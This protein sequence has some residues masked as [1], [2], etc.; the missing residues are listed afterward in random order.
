[1]CV[2]RPWDKTM[3]SKHKHHSKSHNKCAE[4]VLYDHSNNNNNKK[5]LS[6]WLIITM[7]SPKTWHNDLQCARFAIANDLK[8]FIRSDPTAQN[9]GGV[10]N[11]PE[12][13]CSHTLGAI[14]FLWVR[15]IQHQCVFVD[16][17]CLP[18]LRGTGKP[19]SSPDHKS[20]NHLQGICSTN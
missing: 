15:V 7:A 9:V 17:H 6:L 10:W 11:S 18:K 3:W 2:K 5:I 19:R 1:M 13:G 14:F 12:H 20:A 16:S 4:D 8:N